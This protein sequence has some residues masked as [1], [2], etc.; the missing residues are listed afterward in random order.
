MS[1]HM[2]IIGDSR[3]MPEL[4]DESIH[5]T[6]TSPPYWCIKDYQHPGQIGYEQSY[7]EYLD[8]LRE[9][10]SECKRVLK[11]G[12]RLAVNIGDQYLRAKE[13]GRYRVLPI[14]AD[15]TRMGIDLGMDF[16]GA[17]IWRKIST[18]RTTG[19]GCWMGSTYYPGDGHITYEHEYILLFRKR[20]ERP[21]PKDE[22]IRRRSRL[23]KEERSAWFRGVWD[24]V[25]PE[26]QVGHVAMFPVELPRRLIRMYTYVG[27]T[28]LDPFLGSGT[29]SLAAALEGRNSVGYEINEAFEELI[30]RKISQASGSHSESPGSPEITVVRR[31]SAAQEKQ[32]G[33]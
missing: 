12:C 7:E 21:V 29:T 22:D 10:F 8:A 1:W 19:G 28:V 31:Q 24:D 23:T 14:P 11:P 16:M 17:I 9:V 15:V 30:R 4:E 6:V 27:E 26:R 2:V 32:R 3:Q 13:H 18:T 33:K 25:T 20:G 5:L